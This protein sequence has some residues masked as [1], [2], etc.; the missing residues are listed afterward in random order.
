LWRFERGS[1]AS[2]LT[3]VFSEAL[4]RRRFGMQLLRCA[5]HSAA[6]LSW[7]QLLSDNSCPHTSNSVDGSFHIW[8]PAVQTRFG[9]YDC[10]WLGTSTL[11]RVI[12]DDVSESGPRS[13]FWLTGSAGRSIPPYL[14]SAGI[15]VLI[16]STQSRTV[17]RNS[18]TSF[19]SENHRIPFC[20]HAAIGG[21]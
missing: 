7:K 16:A 2:P 1:N 8:A 14:D 21:T 15:E 5:L 19:N 17:C 6:Y 12:S 4:S 13:R 11:A 9:R 10:P 3:F 18:M 20:A